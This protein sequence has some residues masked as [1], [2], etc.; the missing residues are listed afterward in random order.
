VRAREHRDRARD[1]ASAETR[2]RA[3]LSGPIT[4]EDRT[5]ALTLLGDALDRQ[6]RTADAFAAWEQAQHSFRTVYAGTLAPGP[7]RPSHRRFIETITEHVRDA[8]DMP[9]LAAAPEVPGAAA[10]HVFLLGYPRS[11][12]TLVEN[13]L[14]SAPGRRRA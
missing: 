3:L 7:R 5:R 10:T 12:T 9:P 6:D 8:P 13:V 1:G 2:L 14:A 11:G 4:G